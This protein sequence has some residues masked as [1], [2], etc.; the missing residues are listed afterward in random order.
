MRFFDLL[1]N[2]AAA[3]PIGFVAIPV[4]SLGLLL[5]MVGVLLSRV[6]PAWLPALVIVGAVASGFV[7]TGIA[8]ALGLVWA[9]PAG[10][11]VWLVATG[12]APR[13]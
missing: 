4:L 12:R 9:L 8:S 1:D 7:G 5:L 11:I 10:A 2:S 13:S 3:L 6:V